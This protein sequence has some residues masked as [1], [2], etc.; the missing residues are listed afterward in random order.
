MKATS[1]AIPEIFKPFGLHVNNLIV[2]LPAL[3]SRVR[4][5]DARVL[6]EFKAR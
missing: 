3:Q 4:N 1:G 5:Q 6:C 2:R